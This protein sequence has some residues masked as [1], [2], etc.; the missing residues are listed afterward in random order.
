MLRNSKNGLAALEYILDILDEP[1]EL[2]AAMKNAAP[3]KPRIQGAIV[4]DQV[5]LSYPKSEQIALKEF[6][7]DVERG[8]TIALVG[9]SGAGKTTVCNLVSRFYEPT[10]GRIQ[11]DGV[12]LGEVCVEHFRKHLGVVEQDVF[13]FDGTV[14]ENILYGNRNA[15]DAEIRQATDV[16]NATEFI[17]ELPD[18]LETLIGER[19]LRLSGGQRQRIAIARAVAADPRILILDE[20]TSNLDSESERLIQSSL[21]RLMQSRTCFVIAHRLSTITNADQI[22][23]L[24]N[25]SIVEVGDH[26]TLLESGGA[27]K[28]M[29]AIQ[30]NASLSP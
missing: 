3:L 7:L 1:T 13:L 4:F 8:Q 30:T 14:R 25:G 9:R 21:K 2:Q 29:V 15:T 11:V 10:S 6:S 5:S 12:D 28:D 24:D 20:A 22:V 23:V 17:D 26:Q 16:A 27:Y 19:G 18:G